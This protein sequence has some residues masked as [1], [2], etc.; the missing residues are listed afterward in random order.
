MALPRPAGSAIDRIRILLGCIFPG[1]S[2]V[3]ELADIPGHHACRIHPA[4][5]QP[6]QSVEEE[7]IIG[8]VRGVRRYGIE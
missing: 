6:R 4:G 7:T 1:L 5:H 8:R 3:Y 2:V